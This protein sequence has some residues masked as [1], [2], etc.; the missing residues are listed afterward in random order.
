MLTNR[1]RRRPKISFRIKMAK[2]KFATAMAPLYFLAYGQWPEAARPRPIMFRVKAMVNNL[3][4][5]NA[6]NVLTVKA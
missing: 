4:P 3:L 6:V 5:V 2:L 1:Y